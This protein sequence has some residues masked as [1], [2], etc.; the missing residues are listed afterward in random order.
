MIASIRNCDRHTK[1]DCIP[2]MGLIGEALNFTGLNEM[3]AIAI[4]DR[5]DHFF[6]KVSPKD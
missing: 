2:L 6:R 5:S 4:C 3:R 1:M